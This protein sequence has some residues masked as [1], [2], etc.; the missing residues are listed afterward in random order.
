MLVFEPTLETYQFTPPPTR[1]RF[2]LAA[3]LVAVAIS[4][5]GANPIPELDKRANINDSP[6]IS[7]RNHKW[8]VFNMSGHNLFK[9]ECTQVY[10]IV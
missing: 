8:C 1:M 3:V 2:T 5:A 9:I 7:E 6:V 4:L 10:V